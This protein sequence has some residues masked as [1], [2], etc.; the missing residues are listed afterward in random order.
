MKDKK[1]VTIKDVANECGIALSTVSNALVGKQHVSEETRRLV[2]E[3]AERLGYRA[4]AVAR[5]LRMQRSFTIGVLIADV[6]NPAFPDFVRGVEDVAIREKCSLL[7]CNTDGDEE[8]QIWHMR[9]LLDSQVDGMVL[10]SQHI[11]TPRVRELLDSGTPFV[12]VQR[13]SPRH[14][15]DYVGSDNVGGITQAVDHLASLGH[16][17]IGFVRG[18][19]DSSTAAERLEAYKAAVRRLKLDRDA[20]LIFNGDYNLPTGYDAGLR[21]LSLPNRPTAIMAS[22]DL[23]AMGVIEAAMELGIKVPADLSVVGLD[24][25]QLASF[26][27]I[28]LTTIHLQKRTMGAAAAE[29][30]MKRIR[31]QRP[32]P[33]REQI[34]PTGLVVRGST[35][36]APQAAGR[37]RK[38]EAV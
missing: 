24:D 32:S 31:N 34:F 33:A 5:A 22:N 11:D 2:K 18:P 29:M 14:E 6:A 36:R 30:L 9:A 27:R 20:E 28:D 35:A 15:D 4:S 13:R 38:K 21:L 37:K 26:R 10:I 8:K 17:R 7:L 12:L 3:T 1:R 19:M 25:I 23:N 16:T